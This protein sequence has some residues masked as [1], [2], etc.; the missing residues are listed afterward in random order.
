MNARRNNSVKFRLL[1]P[2]GSL[3]GN[4]YFSLIKC[5]SLRHLRKFFKKV[6]FFL[7]V[8]SK[9][10]RFGKYSAIYALNATRTARR[11]VLNVCRPILTI[12]KVNRPISGTK[13]YGN[14]FSCFRLVTY[15]RR[16]KQ[17]KV[18]IRIFVTFLCDCARKDAWKRHVARVEER[19]NNYNSLVGTSEGK[20]LGRPDKLS[21][22]KVKSWTTAFWR[23]WWW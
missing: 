4:A 13:F 2:P 1:L 15:W 6:V 11:S 20:L 12:I 5:K 18:H 14:P 3:F 17:S 9:F 10:S 23:R 7:Q 8:C 19:R 21:P 16:N 22:D